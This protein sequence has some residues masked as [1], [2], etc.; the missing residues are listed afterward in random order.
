M[1]TSASYEA[2]SAPLSYPTPE[3]RL[4]YLVKSC[5]QGLLAHRC[6][7]FRRIGRLRRT[8]PPAPLT[9]GPF[10][11]CFGLSGIA[12]WQ[13]PAFRG[14]K[15]RCWVGPGFH[16]LRKNTINEGYGL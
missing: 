8:L 16:R 10:K 1:E 9:G 15:T 3:V 4:S 6:G 2:R 5:P 11:P 13:V 14:R 7:D 12:A